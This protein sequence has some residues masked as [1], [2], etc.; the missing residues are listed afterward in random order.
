[1]LMK[2]T[3][4]LLRMLLLWV[5]QWKNKYMKTARGHWILCLCS[6]FLFTGC[7]V[8]ESEFDANLDL[9]EI[10]AYYKNIERLMTEV[11]DGEEKAN[12]SYTMKFE[13]DIDD[14]KIELE[15]SGQGTA[16]LSKEQGK[17]AATYVFNDVNIFHS[18]EINDNYPAGDTCMFTS[19]VTRREDKTNAAYFMEVIMTLSFQK[20]NNLYRYGKNEPVVFNLARTDFEDQSNFEDVFKG[21]IF[22]PKDVAKTFL[23]TPPLSAWFYSTSRD[24]I[25]ILVTLSINKIDLPQSPSVSK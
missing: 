17:I 15:D 24:S 22:V 7:V 13:I 16:T 14:R 21:I 2:T 25:S 23:T 20:L 5:A 10:E 9:S 19:V 6:L 18:E 8:E 4:L 3:D 12:V 11:F 1:M